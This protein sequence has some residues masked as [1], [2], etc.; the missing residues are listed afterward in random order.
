[1]TRSITPLS[2]FGRVVFGIE[3]AKASVNPDI[4]ANQNGMNGNGGYW[5]G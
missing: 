4:A 2:G 5:F 1:M 3:H